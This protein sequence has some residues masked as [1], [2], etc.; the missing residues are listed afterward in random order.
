M[1]SYTNSVA[2]TSQ[3]TTV[4]NNS[5]VIPYGNINL[6]TGVPHKYQL[7]V[8]RIFTADKNGSAVYITQLLSDAAVSIENKRNVFII[9]E[10]DPS[11]T[12]TVYWTINEVNKEITIY[13][14]PQ[15]NQQNIGNRVFTANSYSIAVPPISNTNVV[16]IR[17]K[18][19]SNQP[20][21][22]WTPGNT[23]TSNQ[24][25]LETTQLLYL[26]QEVLDKVY[27]QISIGGDIVS[28]IADNSVSTNKI[29][30]L[31]VTTGK[32]NNLAITDAKLASDSVTT[33]KILNS[34]VTTAKIADYNITP[35][36]LINTTQAWSLTG[37]LALTDLATSATG[38]KV[39]NKNYVLD[40]V[41]KYGI[42]TKDSTVTN[43]VFNTPPTIPTDANDDISLQSGGIWF[44]P[45]DGGLR[46]RVLDK[47][48]RVTGTPLNIT[49]YISTN[50]TEQTKTGILNLHNPSAADSLLRITNGS[51]GAGY[52][53][54]FAVGLDG[55]GNSYLWNE[56]NKNTLF[57]TNG[58]ERVR[59][60]NDGNISIGNASAA[61]NTSRFLDIYNYTT[62]VSASSVLR[63]ITH[64]TTGSPS[65]IGQ[66]IKYQTGGFIIENTDTN[67][68]ANIAFNIGTSE[69]MRI[70]SSGNVGINT[71]NPAVTLDVAG[72]GRFLSAGAGVTTGA[73]ILREDSSS[74]P[75]YIQWVNNNNTTNRG[76]IVV[77]NTSNMKFI[78]GLTQKVCINSDGNV[79]IGKNNP[80]TSLDVN[81]IVT[82]TG[83]NIQMLIPIN[84][85][86]FPV[87][88]A[89]SRSLSGT[90]TINTKS[91]CLFQFSFSAY[92]QGVGGLLTAAITTT[93]ASTTFTAYA[94]SNEVNSHKSSGMGCGGVT[95]EAGTY[96][97]TLTCDAGTITDSNDRAYV[98]VIAIP[99]P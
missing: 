8:E 94:Y 19:I 20:L 66:L 13:T 58:L 56:E 23:L 9:P 68:A 2:P 91:L 38:D 17:R 61:G 29:V 52:A 43:F 14:N 71:N 45:R 53:Q 82:A 24:L 3:A 76:N 72:R 35:A 59:I 77:D 64:N 16:T 33:S 6:I 81:G 84:G 92:R 75:A 93:P 86:T 11:N 34:N 87:T 67:A 25:N 55:T 54:G 51:T 99:T 57:G 96:T 42:I 48:V 27:R 47:W 5:L 79:G 89:A 83:Y 37:T 98:S 12:N 41:S 70:D 44:N 97:V 74:N 15:T 30:D 28:Q 73:V 85:L 90:M 18:T 1:P 80:S 78:T 50:S 62:G 22:T 26:L 4:T 36:K 69:R 32:I 40:R 21:V 60:G 31:N 7:E 95:L 88:P 46:V 63:L 39:T 65:S 10:V 49:D